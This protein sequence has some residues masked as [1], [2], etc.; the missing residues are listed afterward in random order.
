M[1]RNS[2]S[3]KKNQRNQ[4][5]NHGRGR[6]EGW[7]R[8]LF[9]LEETTRPGTLN[10]LRSF[11]SRLS[12]GARSLD[13]VAGWPLPKQAPSGW[14]GAI[15]ACLD[16]ATNSC[17]DNWSWWPSVFPA[18]PLH[19]QKAALP[20]GKR[21]QISSGQG[22]STFTFWLSLPWASY[23]DHGITHAVVT[24][25]HVDNKFITPTLGHEV[26]DILASLSQRVSS[27]ENFLLASV[28]NL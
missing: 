1:S 2:F 27:A 19:L 9:F 17:C 21:T 11:A 3:N 6:S 26:A 12:S 16:P 25:N 7:A 10:F 8:A 23:S 5:F 18:L 4:E 22:S 20:L 14:L 24:I 13:L 28:W 15:E